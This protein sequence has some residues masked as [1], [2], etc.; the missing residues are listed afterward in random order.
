MGEGENIAA[1]DGQSG[2]E[3]IADWPLRPWILAGLLALAG[4]LIHFFFDGNS[5]EPAAAAAS[6]FLFFGSLCA[7]FSI[8]PNRLIEPAIFAFVGGLVM[9][10]L[11]YNATAMD[12]VWAGQGF[13]F[14]AGAFASVIALPLFQAGFHRTRFATEYRITHFHVWTDAVSAAGALAFTGLSWVMLLLLN[15][16]LELVG[17]DLIDKLMREEWFAWMWSGGAFGAALGVLRNNLKVIGGLQSVVMIVLSLLAVPL[18]LALMVFLVALLAS[19]GNALWE[20]TDSAT[21]VLLTCAVGCFI[22]ANAIIRDD[23]AARS[24]SLV[25]KVTALVLSAG[26]LPLAIFAAISMGIRIDQYGLAPERIWALVAIIVAV[27]YGLAYWTGLARGRWPNWAHFLR[28]ANL[29][30][31]AVTCVLALLLALP[32]LDFGGISARNQV[33]RLEAG[34]VTVEEFDFTA[35]RWDFGDA[36]RVVLDDLAAG[37][38]E[39]AELAI[40]A[41]AQESRP[42]YGRIRQTRSDTDERLAHLKLDTDDAELRNAVETWIS[43]EPWRCDHPCWVIDAG[44]TSQNSRRMVY[45]EAGQLEHLEV[46]AEGTINMVSNSISTPSDSTAPTAQSAVEIRPFSGRQVYVDGKPHGQ[47]FE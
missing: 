27:A 12:D 17:I 21:P 39:V 26:I 33:A 44:L 37:E 46:T 7:A 5:P 4:L 32:I 1:H 43:N 41:K 13:A 35:L 45:V 9:A 14:A 40:A 38:G 3:L 30:L 22:L 6:A 36:G 20:A 24:S 23:D 16:L 34:R 19:G 11:A 28:R 42:Y 15:A 31:A 47:P 29:Q 2:E 25:L 8:G 18:A 10:G